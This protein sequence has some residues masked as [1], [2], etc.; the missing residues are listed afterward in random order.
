MPKLPSVADTARPTPTPET[1][2]ISIRPSGE[3]AALVD[4][5]EKIAH[6]EQTISVA[7]RKTKVADAVARATEELG[8][9]AIDYE[10]DQ[11]YTT[12]ADRYAKESQ[13]I[14]AKHTA[15]ISDRAT[16][17]AIKNH[18]N[19]TAGHYRLGVYKGAFKQEQDANVAE[20]GSQIEEGLRQFVA[21]PNQAARSDILNSL[22]QSILGKRA[23]NFITDTKAQELFKSVPR[24]AHAAMIERML[25]DR[26]YAGAEAY[27]SEHKN[28]LPI[29]IEKSVSRAVRDGK[30]KQAFDD[31]NG[32]VLDAWNDGKSLASLESRIVKDPMLSE[33]GRNILLGRVQG[34]VAA[35]EH[36]AEIRAR[37]WEAAVG[38]DITR[39]TNIALSG[40]EPSAEQM[41][42]V[43]NAA[44]GTSLEAEARALIATVNATREFRTAPP[45]KQEAMLTSAKIAARNDPSKFDVTLI[46]R[47]ETIQRA[48]KQ[49]AKNDIISFGAQQGLIDPEQAAPIDLTKPDAVGAQLRERYATAKELGRRYGVEPKPL[50]HEEQ[51]ALVT[52]LKKTGPDGKAEYF[53]RLSMGL[54]DDP[55]TYKAVLRQISPDDPVGAIAGAYAAARYKAPAGQV[56]AGTSRSVADLILQGQSI[57]HPNKKED[58]SPDGGK[59][60][61]M[62]P[63]KDMAREWDA[64]VGDAYIGNPQARSAYMQTA[65][66]IYAALASS[67]RKV[68][69]DTSIV[70]TDLW[71]TAM[72]LATGGI[73][74]IGGKK[75]VLPYGMTRSDFVDGLD[76]RLRFFSQSGLLDK[77]LT[78]SA[79]KGLPL[80]SVGDGRYV[81]RSGDSILG[82][83]NGQPLIIDFNDFN[84]IP[85]RPEARQPT[86]VRRG[87]I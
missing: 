7:R 71:K 40:Y 19:V 5:G 58:G 3:G 43:L 63:K 25:N 57:L 79:M 13:E 66:S 51:H 8:K 68:S 82:M 20:L 30:E 2:V 21:A 86:G 1:G 27:F 45:L 52:A 62:P 41:G 14:I 23:A 29:E 60:F 55:E 22:Q 50:T 48:Q 31:M 78:L 17:E 35:I 6:V 12:S 72:E 9:R 87:G 73:A 10:H 84:V 33:G 69:K 80:E 85:V 28:E 44:K 26:D 54:A 16:A 37:K 15:G 56:S 4:L 61:P 49:E 64:Y 53:G 77:A 76:S 70:D 59:T 65:E 47:W 24:R 34:R 74:D 38:K 36:R 83:K 42:A 75:T 81:I 39:L 32:M 67:S 18:L 11:D 46:G